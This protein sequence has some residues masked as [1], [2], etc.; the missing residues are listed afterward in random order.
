MNERKAKVCT[1]LLGIM[2]LA[3]YIASIFIKNNEGISVY[4]FM[5]PML[6]AITVFCGFNK[7]IARFYEWL[8]KTDE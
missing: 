2:L 3:L 7:C 8:T 6:S 1:V 5:M 4:E